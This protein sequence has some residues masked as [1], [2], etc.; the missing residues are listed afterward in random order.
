MFLTPEIQP[1]PG[2]AV[3]AIWGTSKDMEYLSV[4]TFPSTSLLKK[5]LTHRSLPSAIATP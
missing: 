5:I 4:S 2:L 1:G 3:A